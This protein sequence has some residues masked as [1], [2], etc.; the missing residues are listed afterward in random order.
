M[1]ASAENNLVALQAYEKIIQFA[2]IQIEEGEYLSGK[3]ILDNTLRQLERHCK[4]VQ[5][6]EKRNSLIFTAKEILQKLHDQR[7]LRLEKKRSMGV[8]ESLAVN[9]E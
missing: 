4:C 5:L 1:L 9:T 2:K 8:E 7:Q 3:S 6:D